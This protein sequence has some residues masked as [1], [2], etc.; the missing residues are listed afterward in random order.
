MIFF[1]KLKGRGT[2]KKEAKKVAA[3]KMLHVINSGFKDDAVEKMS[4]GLSRL[5][6]SKNPHL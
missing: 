2:N 4:Y 5:E 6:L 1:F 3:E